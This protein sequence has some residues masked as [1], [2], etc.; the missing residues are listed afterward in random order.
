M[1]AME[2]NGIHIVLGGDISGLADYAAKTVKNCRA[3]DEDIIVLPRSVTE[4]PAKK[5]PIFD[6]RDR[7]LKDIQSRFNVSDE[8]ARE[9]RDDVMKAL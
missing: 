6:P 2:L 7:L 4:L 9:M 3:N 1:L 8:I 5:K